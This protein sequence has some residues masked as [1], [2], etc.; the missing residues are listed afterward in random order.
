[1]SRVKIPVPKEIPIYHFLDDLFGKTLMQYSNTAYTV[2]T[3]CPKSYGTLRYK[4]WEWIDIP[5]Y[6][7]PKNVNCS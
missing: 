4:Y 6:R 7:T 2:H 3:G 1:M 5:L